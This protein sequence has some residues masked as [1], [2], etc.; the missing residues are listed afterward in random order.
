M[1]KKPNPMLSLPSLRCLSLP[2]LCN[3]ILDAPCLSLM[4]LLCGV[5]PC[6]QSIQ[7]QLHIEWLIMS[8]L[9]YRQRPLQLDRA[10]AQA[11]LPP[12]FT[13]KVSIYLATLA[14]V[15]RRPVLGD[16]LIALTCERRSEL[17]E[18]SEVVCMQYGPRRANDFLQNIQIAYVWRN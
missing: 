12:S 17:M 5:R 2:A 10:L 11:D 7:K 13:I 9:Q 18:A 4:A 3:L 15:D 8:G 14:A 16:L 1:L 6:K